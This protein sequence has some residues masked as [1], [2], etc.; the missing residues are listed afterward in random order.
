MESNL[1]KSETD[2]RY[3]NVQ[4][5]DDKTTRLIK[6]KCKYEL[7]NERPDAKK[8]DFIVGQTVHRSGTVSHSV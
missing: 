8:G 4:G 3:S 5:N 1:Y 6:E 7:T 2:V